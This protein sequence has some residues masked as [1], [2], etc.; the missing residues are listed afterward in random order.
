VFHPVILVFCHCVI[1]LIAS[2]GKKPANGK[3][4]SNGSNGSNG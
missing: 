2:S 3:N 1:A 4:N